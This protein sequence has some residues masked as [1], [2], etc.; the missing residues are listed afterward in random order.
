V[1]ICGV[2]EEPE[3]KLSKNYVHPGRHLQKRWNSLIVEVIFAY[4]RST[5]TGFESHRLYYTGIV[6]VPVVRSGNEIR[7]FKPFQL[8]DKKYLVERLL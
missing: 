6:W 1:I 4:L 7:P 3:K 5:F 8:F 2:I